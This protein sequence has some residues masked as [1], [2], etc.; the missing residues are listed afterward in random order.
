MSDAHVAL[1]AFL[2]LVERA[3]AVTSNDVSLLDLMLEINE[4]LPQTRRFLATQ[5]MALS[6]LDRAVRSRICSMQEIKDPHSATEWLSLE[7]MYSGCL[8]AVIPFEDF[9]GVAQVTGT[10]LRCSGSGS[11]LRVHFNGHS[12]ISSI[13]SLEEQILIQLS[14]P[15]KMLNVV[16]V[17]DLI[18]RSE[19][20]HSSG[21]SDF[22]LGQEEGG[23]VYHFSWILPADEFGEAELTV[24]EVKKLDRWLKEHSSSQFSIK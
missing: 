16:V 14:L 19:M 11:D 22:G 24:A 17:E 9:T 7:T 21:F 1:I 20:L 4:M 3:L 5:I 12:L 10:S 8:C 2:H 13:V 18:A 15:Q 6:E 23:T